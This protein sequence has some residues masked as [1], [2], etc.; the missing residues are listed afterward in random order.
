MSGSNRP[1]LSLSLPLRILLAGCTLS[2]FAA[3]TWHRWLR[4]QAED[5]IAQDAT[6]LEATITA[7]IEGYLALL[8]GAVGFVATMSEVTRQDFSRY[9][10]QVGLGSNYP[11]IQGI[12]LSLRIPA[13]RLDAVLAAARARGHKDFRVWPD[14]PRD[15]YH[16]IFYLEP[17]DERNRAAIGFDMHTEPVRRAAMDRARDTGEPAMTGRVTLVQ[18]IH[19]AKQAG[20][21]IYLPFYGGPVRP[22]T[23]EERRE[24]LIGYVYAPFRAG[25]FL[26]FISQA[27]L[28]R[29]IAIAVY[30]GMEITSDNRLYRDPLFDHRTRNLVR[31]RRTM[32]VADRVWTVEYSARITGM[33][34]AWGVF[35][36]GLIVSS[37]AS[38]L[39]GRATRAETR[40]ARSEA[41]RQER[42]GEL[43][44]LTESVPGLVSYVD[45][46]GVIRLAN[47]RYR[48][49]FAVEPGSLVGRAL[50]DVTRPH[51]MA[52]IE[53][54]VER[55]MNG[56]TIY[57]ERWHR[58]STGGRYLATHYVP[59][60]TATGEL[61]GFF[62]LSSDLT[63]LKRAEEGATFVAD[64]SKLL[65]SSRDHEAAARGV[66]G[67]A[68]PRIA[69][70]AVLFRLEGEVM[71]GTAVAH[72]HPDMRRQLADFLREVPLPVN[73]RHNLARAARSGS[74][75]LMPQIGP[76]EVE[77]SA[78][79][80]RL[81][82]V[83]AALQLWSVLHVPVV[84]RGSVWAIFTFGTTS[85]SGRR[86]TDADRSLA[87][88]ISTRV[89]LAV[90]NSLLYVEAQQEIEERRRAERAARESE[91]R[92][93]LLVEGARDYAIILLHPDGRIA[94]WNEGAERILGFGEEEAVGLPLERLYSVEDRNAAVPSNELTRASQTGSALDERW[95]L[96]K[97][98]TR[99][100]ASGHTVVLRDDDGRIRGYAKIMRDL[101]ER[102]MLEQ[103]LEQR[104]RERTAEL[105]EAVQELEAFSY[106][107][108]HDLRAP[109]R[110]IRGFTELALEEA[111]PRLGEAERG[112]LARVQRA[113]ARLDQLISDLLAYTRVSKTRVE[114][115]PVD[116]HMLVG[117][118]LREH[119]E[120][121]PPHAVIEV[122]APLSPVTGNLAYLTQC[123]TNLLGNAVKFV[124]PGEKPRVRIWTER[125]NGTVRLFVRDNGIG[126]P[127][128]NLSRAFEMF[129]RLHA[130]AGYE[131]TGVGLAIVRRAVQ[132]MKGHIGVTSTPGVGTTF[133]I[134]LP[135]AEPGVVGADGDAP[136]GYRR[137]G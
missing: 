55:A 27:S 116:L 83:L 124:K 113:V 12:G 33:L 101:T 28:A 114:L 76:A 67:L 134:E 71:R 110:S 54:Y 36:I 52:E 61:N 38:V 111:G 89:R 115:G 1:R 5:R 86:F 24:K 60:R 62:I 46:Q 17:D 37:G 14:H 30:D 77:R 16:T 100:W 22:P 125:Q 9:L 21:L 72:A 59:H 109:L 84:V 58:A 20:F 73:A 107:V 132:R 45:R 133:W 65:I 41:E 8:R 92:F 96:R 75:V 121:Q 51:V 25:D 42:E 136:G 13:D 98:G 68:V 49:W 18:E 31:Q 32:S 2:I 120:L 11:G 126:I 19:F 118:L 105:N 87:E 104:V 48:E 137:S 130:G 70:V 108:S 102:K 64:C 29:G 10:A 47:R 78:D 127:A 63:S 40:A 97:D 119:P 129:E 43:T 39:A 35:F 44:L 50:S 74:V 53:P 90:E 135:A 7:R 128:K 34:P 69:D 99:F 3:I 94:S 93:R 95:Y 131:G 117:D 23:V 26:E 88:E 85:K 80:P 56:E 81:R 122:S 106:S 123:L 112:Y 66:V 79:D 82:D 91:E 6:E 57:F 15:E 103:E 4:A